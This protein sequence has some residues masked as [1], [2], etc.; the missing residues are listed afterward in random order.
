MDGKGMGEWLDEKDE[1]G[2]GI[3][4]PATYYLQIFNDEPGSDIGSL[5]RVV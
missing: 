1:D 2:Y 5:Q 4:V 3:R